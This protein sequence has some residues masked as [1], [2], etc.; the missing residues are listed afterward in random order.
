M[1]NT[2]PARRAKR[3]AVLAV[4]LS[5]TLGQGGVMPPTAEPASGKERKVCKAKCKTQK[6]ECIR[7][8]KSVF[9]LEKETCK[10]QVTNKDARECK[11]GAKTLFKSKK[12][13]CKGGFKPCKACC[14]DREDTAGCVISFSI[15]GDG[16]LQEQETC[17]DGNTVGGDGC[18]ATCQL[19]CG[20][21]QT[22]EGEECEVDRDCGSAGERCIRCACA[23]ACDVD[24]DCQAGH[25][26]VENVC[27]PPLGRRTFSI[28]ERSEFFSSLLGQEFQL[29]VPE[30]TIELEAGVPDENG[31]VPITMVEPTIVR[32]DVNVAGA[33]LTACN[34]V[35]SCEGTLYCDGGANVDVVSELNSL[36]GS[37]T[38]NDPACQRVMDCTAC[39][40]NACDCP[41]DENGCGLSSG[42]DIISSV[43]ANP[44]TDSGAG[45]LIMRC[46][47]EA[48]EFPPGTD[49]TAQEYTKRFSVY[50][51]TGTATGRVLNH[52][53]GPLSPGNAVPE[54]SLSGSNFNCDTWN[55]AGGELVFALPTEEPSS[56][57][58]GD[59]TNIGLL[60]D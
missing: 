32:I 31:A 27:V 29:G 21:G 41:L 13:L 15:C 4:L 43:G 7:A 52:C 16:V 60:R 9:K 26:C 17:D 12:K 48:I 14:A 57:I 42:N 49:C 47:Q 54:V 1:T 56:F 45:A 58:R 50:Y 5:V 35:Y 51:T 22:D 38:V 55:T 53:A 11:K 8:F 44:G 37:T 19:E 24:A 2:K 23:P 33:A 28:G 10:A 34:K 46:E 25:G 18:S 3:A 59:A 6:K 20:N 39:C 40:S 30:G 36:A